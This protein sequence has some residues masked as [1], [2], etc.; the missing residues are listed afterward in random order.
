MAVVACSSPSCSAKVEVPSA[1]AALV[2]RGLYSRALAR[3][4][5]AVEIQAGDDRPSAYCPRCKETT[6]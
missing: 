3:R 5:W 1:S 2:L 6:P 4:R